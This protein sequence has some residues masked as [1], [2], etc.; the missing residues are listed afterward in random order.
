MLMYLHGFSLSLS[1]SLSFSLSL[2][3]W[4]RSKLVRRKLPHHRK[5][6]RR[7]SSGKKMTKMKRSRGSSP[8]PSYIYLC[9]Y[10]LC[11]FSIFFKS[12]SLSLSHTHTHTHTG[13]VSAKWRKCFHA[14]PQPS[15]F[16]EESVTTVVLADPCQ[17]EPLI[18]I[19]QRDWNNSWFKTPI[20]RAPPFAYFTSFFFLFFSF[21]SLSLSFSC[22]VSFPSIL[23]SC[24]FL[25]YRLVT[26]STDEALVVAS[27]RNSH[28]QL[29]LYEY[30][31]WAGI[32]CWVPNRVLNSSKQFHIRRYGLV[33]Q[34]PKQRTHSMEIIDETILSVWWC[35]RLLTEEWHSN[36]HGRCQYGIYIASAQSYKHR[37]PGSFTVQLVHLQSPNFRPKLFIIQISIDQSRINLDI[38]NERCKKTIKLIDKI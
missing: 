7:I 32:Q 16:Y 30:C 13:T 11:F 27:A 15:F 34:F 33:R 19:Q 21:L 3:R 22:L 17:Y 38:N 28:N 10:F 25:C 5:W 36:C 31:V 6:S 29:T 20:T 18:S 8:T 14:W 9:I 23:W 24:L 12:L 35:R 26:S 37:F 1:L 4:R 2:E